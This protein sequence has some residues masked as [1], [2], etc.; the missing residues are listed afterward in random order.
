MFNFELISNVRVARALEFAKDDFVNIGFEEVGRRFL[1]RFFP[2]SMG[3]GY[4]KILKEYSREFSD[5]LVAPKI[6]A[7]F[8]DYVAKK[9]VVNRSPREEMLSVYRE[10]TLDLQNIAQRAT[11][12]KEKLKSLESLKHLNAEQRYYRHQLNYF[13]S[14]NIAAREEIL[15]FVTQGVDKFVINK[16]EVELSEHKYFLGLGDWFKNV[17]YKYALAKTFAYRDYDPESVNEVSN[18]F[19]DLSFEKHREIVRLYEIDRDKFYK[20]ARLYINGSIEHRPS[21]T[22]RL[23]KLMQ[24]SHILAHRRDIIERIIQ[25]YKR[26]DYLSFTNIAPLQIE[27]IFTDI[28]VA[29]GVDESALDISSVNKKI[30]R[31]VEQVGDFYQLYTYYSFKF[32]LVRNAVAHGEVRDG[33]PEHAAIMLMLDLLPVAELTVSYDILSNKVYNLIV[34]AD[35]TKDFDKIL[36]AFDIM[37]DR[38]PRFF[39]WESHK[40]SILKYLDTRSFWVEMLCRVSDSSDVEIERYLSLAKKIR[41]KKISARAIDFIR[42]SKQFMADRRK[43][44]DEFPDKELRFS[45]R[46][47]AKVFKGME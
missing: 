37:P 41:N 31:I 42:E 16:C 33:N 27:G 34:E 28:C 11:L 19:L 14:K 47:L 21:A 20:Q 26:K 35:A 24:D 4:E 17:P 39:E 3:W 9:W 12:I 18:K 5:N 22:Q 6:E 25:L 8:F 7:D 36:H 13:L 40:Y 32:P 44:F 38:L 10:A 45:A 15:A 43:V 29:L 46:Q 23:T 30:D 1:L 2:N